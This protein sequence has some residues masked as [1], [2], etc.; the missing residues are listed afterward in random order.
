MSL[1]EKAI[2]RLK[3]SKAADGN[4]RAPVPLARQTPKKAAMGD[5]VAPHTASM[6]IEVHEEALRASG[7]LASAKYARQ[8]AE[9]YRHIKLPLL[10]SAFGISAPRVDN[11]NLIM[12][13]SALSGEGKT[14]TTINLAL[15]MAMEKD[16]T[17]LLIDADV[18]KPTVS[19]LFG[20]VD[21]PGLLDLLAGDVNS[22]AEVIVH[23]DRPKLRILPAGRP[24]DHATE[25][26]ASDRTREVIDELQSRYSDRIVLFDSPPLLA[27]SEALVLATL[28]GQI[29][30]V[31]AA[32]STPRM[33][34]RE[35]LGLLDPDHAISLILNKTKRRGGSQYGY[36]GGAYGIYGQKEREELHA[37]GD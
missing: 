16:R 14:Q 19:R 7:F 26:L 31:V 8:L 22:V 27:T 37:A 2:E 12:V 25:L 36:Y 10:A 4:N 20:L 5:V 32:D 13:A 24:R 18:A 17:V 33:A 6:S 1:V 34:I 9:E 11:G 3:N 29:A 28:V 35:A 21:A 15:S 30:L 23:T